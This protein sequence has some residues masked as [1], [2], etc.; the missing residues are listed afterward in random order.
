MKVGF[1][2]IEHLLWISQDFRNFL[3]G[4]ML[5]LVSLCPAVFLGNLFLKLEL[6]EHVP[7]QSRSTFEYQKCACYVTEL[8]VKFGK[9]WDSGGW[10]GNFC[11]PTARIKL[12]YQI[13]PHVMT[14]AFDSKFDSKLL[15]TFALVCTLES[16]ILVVLGW[17]H[18][19]LSYRILRCLSRTFVPIEFFVVHVLLVRT[20]L[21][22]CI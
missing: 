19:I 17:A 4:V 20:S 14:L 10:V 22:I 6:F 7:I 1:Y 15:Q 12:P 11:F 16:W 21:W 9:F 8:L 3:P 13:L 5:S 2:Q 18:H